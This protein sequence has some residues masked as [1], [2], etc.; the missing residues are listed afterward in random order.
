MKKHGV[1][2]SDDPEECQRTNLA[3]FE[4][5]G[6]H[7]CVLVPATPAPTPALEFPKCKGCGDRPKECWNL[8]SQNRG[9]C[10]HCNS[11]QG[12]RGAC[13]MVDGNRKHD[14][15]DPWECLTV[16]S[17]FFE[18]TGYHVCVLPPPVPECKGCQEAAQRPMECWGVCD[19]KAG[20]CDACNSAPSKTSS[21]NDNGGSV[22]VTSS[23][24]VAKG[25]CCMKT[26]GGAHAA[27]DPPECKAVDA[28]KING[29][30]R[31]VGYHMCVITPAEKPV[32]KEEAG[33]DGK[34]CG[35]KEMEC[36]DLCGQ[37]AGFCDVCYSDKKTRGACCMKQDSGDHAYSD[38]A[39]CKAVKTEDFKYTGYHMCVIVPPTATR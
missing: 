8:C 2:D 38:P 32:C 30:F 1:H 24:N 13:C 15:G 7:T 31:Y 10:D 28:D 33:R 6:Y 34:T 5:E 3:D 35:G 27:S 9:Y 25:A 20:W 39:E 22:T 17:A 16:D 12:T 26:E 23:A 11:E 29:P 37:R 36:W 14:A 18:N 21:T 4:H 19:G